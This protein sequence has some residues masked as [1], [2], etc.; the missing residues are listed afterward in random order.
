[1]IAAVILLISILGLLVRLR[2]L[3]SHHYGFCFGYTKRTSDK[4]PI[5]LVEW[6]SEKL[7]SFA[8]LP[9]D[10]PLTFGHLSKSVNADNPDGITLKM[11]TT[12]LTF[13]RPFTLPFDSHQ[14]YFSPSE[15]SN[16]LPAEV[17][18]WMVKS[19]PAPAEPHAEDHSKR[20]I[21]LTRLKA[22]A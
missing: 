9:S 15:L 16:Y 12:C 13:G 6:L 22:I 8:A 1:M 19:P 11:I 3:S 20:K 5:S 14:F 21:N 7:N 17:V 4:Q 10:E 2:R 18:T